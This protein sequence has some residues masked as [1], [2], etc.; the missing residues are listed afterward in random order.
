MISCDLFYITLEEWNMR[1]LDCSARSRYQRHRKAIIGFP[2]SSQSFPFPLK[3]LN[4][5]HDFYVLEKSLIS[6]IFQSSP[7]KSIYSGKLGWLIVARCH[8]ILS[9][10]QV[11][12]TKPDV[13]NFIHFASS[14]HQARCDMI[15]SI[16]QVADT[17]PDVYDFIQFASSR[18]QARCDIIL[19]ILQV[20]N[21]Q[22]HALLIFFQNMKIDRANMVRYGLIISWKPVSNKLLHICDIA[23]VHLQCEF[24][25]ESP[26][27]VI[28]SR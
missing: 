17:K 12:D 15:L 6:S 14:R 28:R 23:S 10:L 16:L 26:Y 1:T 2:R 8:M 27:N 11:A 4:S 9:I 20:A 21:T 5:H 7:G 19:F 25:C 24:C 3:Y 22:T 18:H 13:Y